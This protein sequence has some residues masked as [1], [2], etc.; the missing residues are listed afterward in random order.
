MIKRIIPLTLLIALSS[1]WKQLP[2]E[3][4]AED[5]EG[6][7][8][9]QQEGREDDD[10]DA[11]SDLG[12]RDEATLADG[13]NLEK[14][15]LS[16]SDES[17]FP[18][19]LILDDS[20]KKQYLL[21][22]LSKFDRD[23]ELKGK[24][25]AQIR[26]NAAELHNMKEMAQNNQDATAVVGKNVVALELVGQIVSED[27]V[28]TNMRIIEAIIGDRSTYRRQTAEQSNVSILSYLRNT[29]FPN[30]ILRKAYLDTVQTMG[31]LKG[32]CIIDPDNMIDY[33][34]E[35]PRH[36]ALMYKAM[37]KAQEE[38]SK[39]SLKE[40][41]EELDAGFGTHAIE[42][43][44][45]N[46]DIAINCINSWNWD[47][48]ARKK[49][50]KAVLN[51][52]NFSK[53][54]L[55]IDEKVERYVDVINVLIN[56]IGKYNYG[57][58]EELIDSVLGKDDPGKS[59]A[60]TE[61]MRKMTLMKMTGDMRRDF[62]KLL[63]LYKVAKSI[64]YDDLQ[65]EDSC[66]LQPE[67]IL[68]A[69]VNK[70][71][72]NEAKECLFIWAKNPSQ[73]KIVHK[74]IL[75]KIT[76]SMAKTKSD[77][78]F[79][80]E[81]L[82]PK[83]Q[84][85]RVD[86][87]HKALTAYRIILDE[88]HLQ[89]VYNGKPSLYEIVDFD[90][91]GLKPHHLYKIVYKQ[92]K[93]YYRRLKKNPDTPPMGKTIQAIYKD[94]QEF[95]HIS[96]VFDCDID[97][98]A[99]FDA[100]LESP[101][102]KQQLVNC[103]SEWNSRSNPDSDTV[104]VEM[105]SAKALGDY[106]GKQLSR[107]N[108]LYIPAYDYR[109][110]G[111]YKPDQEAEIIK[112][113]V[114]N[115]INNALELA[116]FVC[117]RGSPDLFDPQGS[118]RM[119][120]LEDS[121]LEIRLPLN[122]LMPIIGILS[123]AA[124]WAIHPVSG[125][126]VATGLATAVIAKALPL[127]YSKLGIVIPALGGA[128]IAAN[129]SGVRAKEIKE[130]L[131]TALHYAGGGGSAPQVLAN[132]FPHF[133]NTH[134]RRA[135][136]G[137]K[138]D[139]LIAA[140]AALPADRL[141][142]P[143]DPNAVGGGGGGGG[144]DPGYSTETKLKFL[145][146]PV[147]GAVMLAV[148]VRWIVKSSRLDNTVIGFVNSSNRHYPDLADRLIKVRS[149]IASNLLNQGIY[150]KGH[151]KF[152][153]S[154]LETSCPFTP[155][156]LVTGALITS[157]ELVLRC[158][159]SYALGKV[160]SISEGDEQ[161]HELS[162]SERLEEALV[163][164]AERFSSVESIMPNLW[165]MFV[166]DSLRAMI[167][168]KIFSETRAKQALKM[169]EYLVD[170]RLLD[171]FD[172]K[173]RLSD[174]VMNKSLRKDYHLYA[175]EVY[176]DKLYPSNNLLSHFRRVRKKVSQLSYYKVEECKWTHNDLFA[177]ARDY[178]ENNRY[179]ASCLAIWKNT[180]SSFWKQ[181]AATKLPFSFGYSNYGSKVVTMLVDSITYYY[182]E[183]RKR[184][185]NKESRADYI[186]SLRLAKE[187]VHQGTQALFDPHQTIP[188][189][190]TPDN[191]GVSRLGE[192]YRQN[193]VLLAKKPR[194]KELEEEKRL[195][196][197]VFKAWDFPL[198]SLVKRRVRQVKPQPNQKAPAKPEEGLKKGSEA[199]KADAKDESSNTQ[200]KVDKDSDSDQEQRP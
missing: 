39:D 17:F 188:A 165:K 54:K 33:Y 77:K 51:Y 139:D 199:K 143:A 109:G 30:V 5:D 184:K 18:T 103:I 177:K 38:M 149:A 43:R 175:I 162:P 142:L 140:R 2:E 134:M 133:F 8:V 19:A 68:D 108:E 79:V 35:F 107:I 10:A 90:Q 89:K 70:D 117:L 78:T 55:R 91:S 24:I 178:Q 57:F 120:V 114:I 154:A 181:F 92:V 118:I 101:E 9:D 22:C 100:M 96:P 34:R 200:K 12:S 86:D 124:V 26:K 76:A 21:K 58:Y 71:L 88:L 67:G 25:I 170:A 163:R 13:E 180:A 135:P 59:P 179:I 50:T 87:I 196:E 32:I 1:C 171:H 187:I 150:E 122:F 113:D 110:L 131:Y 161:D 40:S 41:E 191:R 190:M 157:K 93:D 172:Y 119:H 45:P 7:E 60:V 186:A 183:I 153:A 193:Q 192:I 52:L 194:D 44:K 168:P 129:V 111:Y 105:R 148:W 49:F 53:A 37:D 141:T 4:A 136:F 61:F 137:K 99:T 66:V 74:Q 6:V 14:Q 189:L 81:R 95:L 94:L 156:E 126:F 80:F 116:E 82:D 73:V 98:T 106:I 127:I 155:E 112:K 138:A 198:P 69:I 46:I 75:G 42:L 104:S 146:Y 164:S 97:E 3:D 11:V 128:A 185:V 28:E 56:F 173:N 159:N 23:H 31:Y 85:A 62:H 102:L 48:E 83:D 84:Q 121:P 125:A 174:I 166:F 144:V 197:E 151:D 29:K 20:Q 145:T 130:S 36:F 65:D 123:L 152:Y 72:Q 132:F 147:I 115:D 167:T 63:D 27:L 47:R 182:S 195:I 158:L 15:T 176:A 160:K 64:F 169:L 16:C